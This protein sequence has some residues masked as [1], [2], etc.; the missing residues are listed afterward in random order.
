MPPAIPFFFTEI[1]PCWDT[2]SVLIERDECWIM[3]SNHILFLI[4]KITYYSLV[5]K[6]FICLNSEFLIQFPSPGARRKGHRIDPFSE[7]L[8]HPVIKTRFMSK[9]VHYLL[10]LHTGFHC[11]SVKSLPELRTYFLCQAAYVH[12][13]LVSLKKENTLG[14]SCFYHAQLL[15]T[16]PNDLPEAREYRWN[17]A[18]FGNCWWRNAL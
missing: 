13:T 12:L 8:S 4:H 10:C 11:F 18:T 3:L 6:Y 2:S 1:I 7:R 15:T 14:A 5:K 17:E 9:G 16:E